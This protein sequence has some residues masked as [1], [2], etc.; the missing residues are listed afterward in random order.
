MEAY[1]GDLIENIITEKNQNFS[2]VFKRLEKLGNP[3]FKESIGIF[4]ITIVA[5]LMLLAQ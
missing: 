1:L 2:K 3:W 4:G 5:N